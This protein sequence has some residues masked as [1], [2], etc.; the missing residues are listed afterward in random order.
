MTGALHTRNTAV[1]RLIAAAGADDRTMRDV[2]DE[3]GARTA[4]EIALEELLFRS[5]LR[6]ESPLTVV[7]GF[8]H[9]GT[10]HTF[11]ITIA[12]TVAAGPVG[13]DVRADAVVEQAL[14]E[15]VRDLFAPR[16]ARAAATRAIRW[17]D[18]A[19][20]EHFGRSLPVVNVVRRLLDATDRP[21]A[22]GLVELCARFGS[23][24][25]GLHQYPRH[26][27]RHFEPIRDRP[28]TVLEI[29]VGGYADPVRGGASLRMWR[30][31]FPRALIYGLDITDKRAMSGQRMIIR[32]GDQSS[33]ADL[34][35]VVAA[36]GPLDVVIDDGSHVSAHVIAT[37]NELFSAVRPGG[38]YVIEDLQTSY[39]PS[40]GGAHWGTDEAATS[41]GFLKAL[42]DG[43]NH[44]E[45]DG[46]EPQGW[47]AEISGL[48]FY[49]NMAVIEK[50]K[51]LDGGA[52][53][54][55]PRRDYQVSD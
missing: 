26:Y 19:S 27:E 31:Y 20:P 8:A 44:E 50:K 7:L 54:W 29:G 40:F 5:D 28:L 38:L 52:P 14:T 3:V 18:L 22:T 21:Y 2:I 43:L 33:A 51:N 23:D 55:I 32:Q 49:H 47:D 46:R 6:A 41:V 13:R 11:A 45:I 12:D 42:V 37:F 15:V 25:W 30:R 53:S 16:G 24:K 36:T 9:D 17:R 39:W 4:A 35:D 48:H 1:A 34:A 10:Q